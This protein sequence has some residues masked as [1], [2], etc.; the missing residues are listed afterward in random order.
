[1]EERDGL[2]EHKISRREIF[3]G[4]VLHVVEDTVRLPNGETATREICLHV[5]AVCVLPLLSDGTVL[6]ERQY[7]YAHG[8]VF[9]EIPAGKLNFAGEDPLLAAKRE[10][11]EE[12]GAVAARY[13]YLG[14]LDT[15]PALVDEKISMYLAEDITFGERSLDEDEFLTVE[16]VPLSELYDMVM[17]GEIR[18]A[19]TQISVLKV[20]E[21]LRKR[22]ENAN[23]DSQ[24]CDRKGEKRK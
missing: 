20:W 10:L 2:T 8:R 15:T 7:R 19:K 12:T 3:R 4:K 13:T 11:R 24:S 1:M 21:I 14:G 16:R 22:N 5:G 18:D 6:M 23:K 17:R 9:F